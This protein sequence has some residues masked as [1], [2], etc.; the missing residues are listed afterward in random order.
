[1]LSYCT[2]YSLSIHISKGD[3][4]SLFIALIELQLHKRCIFLSWK[5]NA[6]EHMLMSMEMNDTLNKKIFM[7]N[8]INVCPINPETEK[9]STICY[10]L[11]VIMIPRI[12]DIGLHVSPFFIKSDEYNCSSDNW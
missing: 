9:G 1:M 2:L 10:I 4:D 7:L 6:A 12:N 5:I 8:I 3:R 11:S